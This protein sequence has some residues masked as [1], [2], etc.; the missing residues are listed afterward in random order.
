[1]KTTASPGIEK[2][3]IA[4]Q[5]RGFA[6]WLVSSNG[7][8]V[9]E[10]AKMCMDAAEELECHAAEIEKLTRLIQVD[11]ERLRWDAW[12]GDTLVAM[13]R[14]KGNWFHVITPGNKDQSFLLLAHAVNYVRENN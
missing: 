7:G 10:E 11:D 5:L 14:P 1:M 8:N 9:S 12:K 4:S 6:D 13:I 3:D 2:S